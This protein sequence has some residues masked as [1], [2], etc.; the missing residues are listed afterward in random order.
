MQLAIEKFKNDINL[1]IMSNSYTDVAA[2]DYVVEE[3]TKLLELEKEQI[4]EAYVEGFDISAEGWNGEY[5][6]RDFN[7]I[8]EEIN[9]ED[10]YNQTYNQNK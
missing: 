5:G 3:L 1:S 9:A 2:Y 7:N 6:I 4:I 8:K 10:Y